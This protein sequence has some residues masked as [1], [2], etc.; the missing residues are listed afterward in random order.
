M[1]FLDSIE[2]YWNEVVGFNSPLYVTPESV[3]QLQNKDI[4]QN[5]TVQNSGSGGVTIPNPSGATFGL[6]INNPA[7]LRPNGFS[8][9]GQIGLT[10][11]TKNNGTAIFDTIGNGLRAL[12]MD[13][14][15]KIDKDGYNTISKIANV[16]APSS[17]G[18]NPTEWANLVSSICGIGVN[19][20]LISDTQTIGDLMF[21]VVF[22][23]QGKAGLNAISDTDIINAIYNYNGETYTPNQNITIPTNY[24]GIV[25]ILVFAG[26]GYFSYKYFKKKNF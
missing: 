7:D 11:G 13:L 12:A 2:S 6:K 24:S 20:T 21:G 18:N 10:T 15:I 9:D 5:G 3:V 8:Y 22:A 1:P 26:V 4:T 25:T 23:E 17:D 14:N 19:D 16:Y